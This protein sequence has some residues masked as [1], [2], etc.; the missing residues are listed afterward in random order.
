TPRLVQGCARYLVRVLERPPRAESHNEAC[1]GVDAE[2][3]QGVTILPPGLHV[4]FR[5]FGP[6]PVHKRLAASYPH[7][8]QAISQDPLR[9][10]ARSLPRDSSKGARNAKWL[11]VEYPR[12]HG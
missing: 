1:P 11:S 9:H 12:V 10:R 8:G 4:P 7:R 3:L 5:A 6:S 2:P